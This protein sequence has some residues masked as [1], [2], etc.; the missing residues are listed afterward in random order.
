VSDRKRWEDFEAVPDDGIAFLSEVA[1]VRTRKTDNAIVVTLE[2][3]EQC[4]PQAALLMNCQRTGTVLQAVLTP[5]RPVF[6]GRRSD[7]E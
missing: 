2:L 3:P 7:R 1:S 5:T 4:V 6:V